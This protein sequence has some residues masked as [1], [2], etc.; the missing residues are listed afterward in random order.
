MRVVDGDT[1]RVAVGGR[2]E[3][4]RYIGVDTPETVKP[5]T[6]VQCFGRAR[7]RLQ[8]ATARPARRCGS[9]A[10]A[11]GARPL[12]A[13]ARLRLPRARRPVRQRRARRGAA[14]RAPLDD[15]ARTSRTPSELPRRCAARRAAPRRAR[16]VVILPRHKMFCCLCGCDRA[17]P[18]SRR[19]SSRR[20]TQDRDAPR[21][22]ARARPIQRSRVA[23]PRARPQARHAA[24]RVARALAHRDRRRRD[25]RDVRDAVLRDGLSPAG[26]PRSRAS[27]RACASASSTSSRAPRRPR[28]SPA[29][30]R[31]RPPCGTPGCP[32]APGS[33]SGPSRP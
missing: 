22:A 27:A 10:D 8:R 15:P 7:E 17:S 11:R 28:R 26:A 9:C 1:I 31:G 29:G 23:A 30:S 13:A 2:E 21:A 25:G 14:T 20:S 4:V 12:R 32:A 6:P 18:R 19:P 24:L 33:R 3:R 5:G 16:A